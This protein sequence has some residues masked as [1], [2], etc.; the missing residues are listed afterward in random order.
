VGT[1]LC[2]F[3]ASLGTTFGSVS[4]ITTGFSL[5][6]IF[7]GFGAGAPAWFLTSELVSP[8]VV[9]TAQA[10]STGTLLVVTGL[11]TL[12]FLPLQLWV[13]STFSL[14]MLSSIPA[15]LIAFILIVML[16]ETKDRSFEKIHQLLLKYRFPGV[17]PS[18]R[19]I[20]NSSSTRELEL[21]IFQRGRFRNSHSQRLMSAPSYLS[22]GS[23]RN[24]GNCPNRFPRNGSVMSTV[25][26]LS[27]GGEQPNIY[28]KRMSF[29]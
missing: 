28:D 13:G 19:G 6:K 29:A 4:I 15:L 16:P 2:N 17:S 5:T 8:S 9:C 21:P 18:W 14:L 10:I 23:F 11:C 20:C 25:R 26:S 24:F 27:E 22:Y 12:S 7:I 1:A 3:V